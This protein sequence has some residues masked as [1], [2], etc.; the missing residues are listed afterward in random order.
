MRVYFY[1][2]SLRLGLDSSVDILEH[3]CP[4]LIIMSVEGPYK[5]SK[6]ADASERN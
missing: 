1:L 5:E 4:A 3:K 2:L 6:L